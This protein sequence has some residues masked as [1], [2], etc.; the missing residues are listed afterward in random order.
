MRNANP[1]HLPT[2][3]IAQSFLTNLYIAKPK[4]IISPTNITT[5]LKLTQAA[6]PLEQ[7]TDDS[8]PPGKDIFHSPH[9]IPA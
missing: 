3:Q 8:D 4:K 6:A 1:H 5:G 7:Q 2:P 9:K